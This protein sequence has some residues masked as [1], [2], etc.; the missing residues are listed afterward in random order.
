[1]RAVHHVA[2]A[3]GLTARS[4]KDLERGRRK[5]PQ[6][7]TLEP[8]LTALGLTD[9]VA[10]LA[11]DRSGRQGGPPADDGA[12]T[13]GLLDR[14]R[15]LAVLERTRPRNPRPRDRL[16]RSRLLLTHLADGYGWDT[17]IGAPG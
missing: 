8:L 6:R 4:I 1:M 2:Q 5:R 17:A 16:D 9:A 15:Q 3:A 13:S 7:R 11:A 10:L 12:I 14:R